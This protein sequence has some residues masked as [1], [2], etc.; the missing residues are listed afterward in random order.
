MAQESSNIKQKSNNSFEQKY[1]NRELSWLEFNARILEEAENQEVPLFERLKFLSIFESNLDEFYMVRVAGLKKMLKEGITISESP[2]RMPIKLNLQKIRK[3]VNELLTRKVLCTQEIF[4][5][6]KLH[7]IS[8]KKFSQLS[9]EEKNYLNQYFE[10]K[11]FPVLTPL[12]FDP[13]HPFPSISNLALYLVVTFKSQDVSKGNPIGFVEIPS[14]LPGLIPIKSHNEKTCYIELQELVGSNLHKLFHYYQVIN[15]N[16]FRITRN[17]DYTL[18]ENN[19]VDLLKSLQ[20]EMIAREQ[21]EA[22]RLEIDEKTDSDVIML[23]QENLNLEKDDI[24]ILPQPIEMRN[25]A[26]IYKLHYDDLKYQSFNPRLPSILA[27]NESIFSI[28]T[29]T[30]LLVHHPYESFY[31]VTEFLNALASDEKVLAIKQTLY[32][33]SGDSPIIETLIRAAENGKKV[34][35]VIE[36]KAR[37]D[38]KN[39]IVWARRLERAGVNV[40]FGFVGFKTHCKATLAVRK[41]G[42]K[43]VRYTHLSTGNYNSQSAKIYTDLG[44]FTS[45]EEIGRDISILFNILTGIN[46]LSPSHNANKQPPLPSLNC[47]IMSPRSMREQLLQLISDEI[48]V[49]KKHGNGLIFAKMNALVDRTIIDKLYEAS[50]IGVQIKLIIRGIC[51]LKPQVKNLSENIEVISIID[52]FLEHSRI[53]CFGNNDNTKIYLG[54]AD[55]MPRNMDRRIEIMFP[56]FDKKIKKRIFNEILLL[57]WADNIKARSLLSDGNY[58]KK[59]KREEA[60]KLRAQEAL[61]SLIRE[62]GVKSIPYEKAIRHDFSKRKGTRP[63]AKKY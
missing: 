44:L 20:K 56:I 21:Q 63:I 19:V 27:G 9:Q 39:N 48:E 42:N 33:T 51:C 60:S 5:Q 30:D 8:I 46:M 29:R 47:I 1:F 32:R 2:D 37:F 38:E 17:L 53:Y 57:Y 12:A 3:R 7:N 28:L 54:S 31:A 55:W 41:E 61:I 4:E 52:R 15:F 6:L 13:S 36:L 62:E 22:V 16:A 40:V 25:F 10:E 26:D 50:A 43:L 58:R 45:N 24:F 49:Q 14:I 18:L 35:A 11:I 23:L 34:T 59:E